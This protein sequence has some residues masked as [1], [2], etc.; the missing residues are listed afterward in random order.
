MVV[1]CLKTQGEI[2][3][4]GNFT[5][6]WVWPPCS[7]FPFSF[8]MPGS[9]AQHVAEVEQKSDAISAWNEYSILSIQGFVYKCGQY[10]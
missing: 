7:D 1:L 9:L 6:T 10:L 2:A 8:S 5:F 3:N 4:T